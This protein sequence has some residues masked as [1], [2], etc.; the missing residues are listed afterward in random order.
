ME[1]E[2]PDYLP[3]INQNRWSFPWLAFW[4]IAL[5][6][7]AAA[8]VALHLK[9]NEAWSQRFERAAAGADPRMGHEPTVASTD[10]RE[11]AADP[12]QL[13]VDQHAARM[14][15]A[16]ERNR[17]EAENRRCVSGT[18]FRKIPGGWENVPGLRC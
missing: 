15:Q 3:P 4:A 10:L 5:A 16:R 18:V 12:K 9:T 1:R 17:W 11:R 7:M 14:R 13:T 6:A 8:G 2:R